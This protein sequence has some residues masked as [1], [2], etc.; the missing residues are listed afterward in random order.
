MIRRATG[1]LALLAFSIVVLGGLARGNSVDFIL[2]RA[3]W[4]MGLFC[5]LG[6]VVGW[7][8]DR[9]VREHRSKQYEEVFGR[10]ADEPAAQ[11]ESAALENNS[12]LEP[13][14]PIQN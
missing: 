4:A 7:A 12:T 14:A 8:A 13:A 1:V 6:L 3:L 2:Q 5:L 9:V 11:G 10:P